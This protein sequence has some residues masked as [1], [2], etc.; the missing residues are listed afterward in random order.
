MPHLREGLRYDEACD[1]AGYNHSHS[2]TKEDLEN[3][4]L[5][6]V[7]EILPKNALRNPI[8]EKIL[9]QM[10]NVI[11]QIIERYGKPDEI[12]IE[13]ARDLKQSA[14]ERNNAEKA[15]NTA[16]REHEGFRQTLKSEFGFENPSRNDIIRYKLYKELEPNGFKTLYSN[17]YISKQDLF[18]EKI[19]I[20]HIIP[21]SKLFDDSFSNKTLE[22]R[23]V[24]I[25]KG[26]ATAI[27]FIQTEYGDE[28]DNSIKL[29]T[30]RIE[31]LSKTGKIS[32]A[33]R[34]K[35]LMEEKNIPDDFINRDLGNTRYIAKKAREILLEI[36]KVVTPTT[37]KIT[38]RLREDWQ[39]VDVLKELTIDKYRALGLVETIENRHGD[40]SERIKDWSK[41][42]D[43]RHHAMDA[44]T[45]AF[46]KPS[47]IQYLNN[48]NAKGD[49][50]GVIYGIEQ[51]ELERSDKGKLRFK[52][53]MEISAFRRESKKHLENILISFKAKNKVT[54]TNKVK[55]KG[56]VDLVYKT[57]RGQLHLETVYGASKE[58][59]TKLEKVNASFDQE[60]IEKVANQRFKRLLLAR[61]GEFDDDASKAFTGKNTLAK[62]PIWSS[63]A[64]TRDASFGRIAQIAK[65][66]TRAGSF[67]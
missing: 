48:M 67:R 4:V 60:K 10:I 19:D 33:K 38:D 55:R 28:G 17:Q 31:D 9:N 47:Y 66:C 14:V 49:K 24:N 42:N 15:M 20:E 35:L 34:R 53:P 26:N 22:F 32:L 64:S 54:T 16:N 61:L 58:Y 30:Q 57:P 27:D 1:K 25:K 8:V 29:F 43:H 13:L 21:K 63:V 51:K 12:R 56:E 65:A 6:D 44:I 36:V 39:L 41:R 37:G 62:N 5:K 11:N 3:K 46:T 40:T 50:N 45:V 59:V 18:S 7:L 52:C 2:E 23:G